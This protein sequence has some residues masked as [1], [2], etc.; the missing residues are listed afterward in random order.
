MILTSC[1]KKLYDIFLSSGI[2]KFICRNALEAMSFYLV[3]LFSILTEFDIIYSSGYSFESLYCLFS[4]LTV[5]CVK[6]DALYSS[7]N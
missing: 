3:C 1:R 2:H 4:L 7:A 6:M 5:K